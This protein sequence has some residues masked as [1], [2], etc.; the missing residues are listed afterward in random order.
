MLRIFIVNNRY[1]HVNHLITI[2]NDKIIGRGSLDDKGP[3][4]INLYAMQNI[5][6][7]KINLNKRIRLIIGCA[8]ETTWECMDKYT[9]T[10]EIPTIGYSPDANF[11][12]IHAE[13]TI[14]QMDAQSTTDVNFEVEAL[15]AYNAVPSKASYK[16]PEVAKLITELEKLGFEYRKID[17]KNI[18]VIGKG[19]F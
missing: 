14:A 11:P 2:V 15:G 8:E 18:E 3:V 12:G 5:L 4:V 13:K 19:A 9:K 1:F 16:G 17:D 6:D 10:E 7:L